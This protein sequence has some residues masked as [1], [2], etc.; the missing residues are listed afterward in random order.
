LLV[1]WLPFACLVQEMRTRSE[2]R[3]ALVLADRVTD[4]VTVWPRFAHMAITA[5]PPMPVRLTATTGLIG[6]LAGSL[7]APAHGSMDTT[8]A[9]SMVAD[10]M[11]AVATMVGE[12]TTAEAATMGAVLSATIQAADIEAV[13]ASLRTAVVDSTAEADSTAAVAEASMVVEA[14]TDK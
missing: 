1:C 13:A 9:G 14:G 4:T 5:M 7:L 3:L 8:V 6:S 12:D 2:W 10:S 11:V